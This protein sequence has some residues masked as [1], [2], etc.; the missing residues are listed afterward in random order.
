M[1]RGLLFRPPCSVIPGIPDRILDDEPYELGKYH[2]RPLGCIRNRRVAAAERHERDRNE[3]TDDTADH[4]E[5]ERVEDLRPEPAE[6]L[7]VTHF[8]PICIHH[9]ELQ[10]HLA[11]GRPV[12]PHEPGLVKNEEPESDE[13]PEHPEEDENTETSLD[14][15][16]GA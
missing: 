11:R 5:D 14:V 1:H 10:C 6:G 3:E 15:R 7:E 4:P 8:R 2:P 13:E 16:A 12:F 9:F